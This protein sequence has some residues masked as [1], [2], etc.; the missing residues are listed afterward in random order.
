[1]SAT[2]LTPWDS[3]RAITLEFDWNAEQP[4]I[5]SQPATAVYESPHRQIVIRQYRSDINDDDRFVFF[6]IEHLLALIA[7][8]QTYLP[9]RERSA[10]KRDNTAAERKRRQRNRDRHVDVTAR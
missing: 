8:L 9:E 4:I 2:E 6:S 1:M 7:E 5:A 3:R 10:R